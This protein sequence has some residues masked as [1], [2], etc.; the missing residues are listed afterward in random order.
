MFYCIKSTLLPTVSYAPRKVVRA[1][2][3]ITNIIAD[4]L[5]LVEQKDR[6]K[7]INNIQQKLKPAKI[8]NVDLI[9]YKCHEKLF[10]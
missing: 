3:K 5:H 9:M 2:K 7:I 4:E 10:N 6:I 8:Y 1:H